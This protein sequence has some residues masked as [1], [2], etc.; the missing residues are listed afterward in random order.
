M[1]L[2]EDRRPVLLT[3][4]VI[5]AV[6][7][8]V[9]L[10]AIVA[11]HGRGF[12]RDTSGLPMRLQLAL[13]EA[14]RACGIRINNTLRPRARKPNGRV[15]MHALWR[16]ADITTRDYPCV[17][18]ALRS[19]PG[20]LSTDWRRVKHVH[21]DDSHLGKHCRFAHVGKT[22]YAA[23][24]RSSAPRHVRRARGTFHA[25][26]PDQSRERIFAW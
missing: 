17:M 23:S 22:R 25:W 16:A 6:A 19:W 18:R 20:C 9:N 8:A 13:K 5:L 10:I 11:A 4:A 26:Y 2:S 12:S 14:D 21:I 3:I 15:S 1:L 7:V 24:I